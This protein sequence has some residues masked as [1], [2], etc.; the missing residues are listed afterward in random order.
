MIDFTA[1][2]T[3]SEMAITSEYFL[4][5]T[6]DIHG[7]VISSDSG[8]GPMPTLF[9]QHKTPLGFQDC[10][11]A[12]DWTKYEN[13]RIRAWKNSQQS[14][15]VTLQKIVHPEGDTMPTK[16]EFFFMTEDFG[17]CLGI[18]HPIIDRHPY[19]M[20][21]GDYFDQSSQDNNQ[22]LSGLLEDR[23]LGFWEYDFSKSVNTMS[24]GLAK[25][26]GYNNEELHKSK[27]AFGKHIHPEDI[28]KLQRLI[29][30][31]Y[32]STSTQPFKCE[33]R[34]QSKSNQL[35][36]VHC[37]GK[38][39]EWNKEGNPVLM[40][41]CMIDITE[42]KKQQLWM[43]DHQHFLKG[44]VHDQS[45]SLRSKVANLLGLFE[46]IEIEEDTKEVKRL[47]EVMKEET[48]KLDAILKKSILESV[49]KNNSLLH[50]NIT[51]E[52]I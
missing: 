18:G 1:L 44:L 36:W 52:L 10:F 16:W 25:M 20:K 48:G 33:F 13:K 12:S 51:S 3:L 40:Q 21:F 39:T 23:L 45:H 19:D 26:L 34:I 41:G 8:I 9:E 14:F 15:V 6:I 28:K 38:T 35:R 31:H 30:I 47:I 24:Q 37:F 50:Q 5:A 7:N 29:S 4:Q 27:L 49:Q 22:V 32:K 43:K 46:I 2:K 42:R 11:L 17:T